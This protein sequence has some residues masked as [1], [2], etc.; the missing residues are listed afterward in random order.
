M[1]ARHC[2]DGGAMRV[3]AKTISFYSRYLPLVQR[4]LRLLHLF[5]RICINGLEPNQSILD[6]A[7]VRV[8][9]PI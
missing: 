8:P 1:I 7:W 5:W 4:S 2:L 9:P 6:N 3:S